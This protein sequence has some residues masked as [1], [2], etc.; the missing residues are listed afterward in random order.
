MDA[1]ISFGEWI[2][3]RRR[4]LDLTQDGLAALVNLS[5]SAIRK[6]ETDER[7]PSRE[8]AELL[9]EALEIPSDAHAAFLKTARGELAIHRLSAPS[10]AMP[11]LPTP[12]PPAGI[13]PV[14]P[15][16][17]AAPLPVVAAVARPP[18]LP[19]A[20]TPL[21]GRTNELLQI[22]RLLADPTCRLLTIVGPGGIGKTRLALEAATRL[23][24]PFVDGV[25]FVPLVSV[26]EPGLIAPTVA[27]AI[28]LQLHGARSPHEQVILHLQSR[29]ALL[30][31][32][33]LEHLLAPASASPAMNGSHGA[34]S[35]DWLAELLLQAPHLKLLTTSREPLGLPGEWLFDL[36]GLPTPPSDLQAQ[37]DGPERFSSIELFLQTARRT[38]ARFAPSAEDREAIARICRLVDG[39]PLGIEL[40]ASWVRT[41][42]CVEIADEIE[43]NLD[44]L[45][46][47]TRGLPERHRSLTAVVEQSWRLLSERERAA[48]RR[49]SILRGAFTRAA[50]EEVAGVNLALLSALVAKS[51]VRH[52]PQGRY[53]LHEV[54]RHYAATQL[55]AYPAE[56]ESAGEQHCRYF[57]GWLAQR[58]GWL[59]GDKQTAALEEFVAEADNI[60]AAWHW[61]VAQQQTSVIESATID[62]IDFYDSLSWFEEAERI[63]SHAEQQL[64]QATSPPGAL[65]CMFLG[66]GAF[67]CRIGRYDEAQAALMRSLILLRTVDDPRPLTRV[68]YWLTMVANHQGEY[69]QARQWAE[70][71]LALAEAH[72]FRSI[73]ARLLN[74]LGFVALYQGDYAQAQGWFEQALTAAR[75]LGNQNLIIL[76]LNN[77]STALRLQ[78]LYDRARLVLQESLTLTQS[79][80]ERRLMAFAQG[81]LGQLAFELGELDDAQRWFHQS[82][83]LLQEIH[84]IWGMTGV[85]NDLGHVALALEQPDEAYQHFFDLLNQAVEAGLPPR[86]L[87]AL[88]GMASLHQQ[89]GQ[90][91]AALA[92]VTHVMQ[93]PAVQHETKGRAERLYHALITQLPPD[94]AALTQAE[95]LA[96]PFSAL[97]EQYMQRRGRF[98]DAGA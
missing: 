94:E 42:T 52:T 2:R 30:L 66:W 26:G 25:Y 45:A 27:S 80:G 46:S 68:Y 1:P 83:R 21:I 50:A 62:L 10:V 11:P 40:A 98:T 70:L 36:H 93:H 63:F 4:A 17:I 28:G 3:Q 74:L 39:L 73:Y 71:G 72:D 19:R 82:L 69:H 32:D 9:A 53:D 77:L 87:D 23:Q 78:R 29:R 91:G 14:A 20:T 12:P 96:Q 90:V 7:R 59:R 16:A 61:A 56:A 33:N 88:T 5:V 31:L 24:E 38:D 67:S 76:L 41:L 97:V 58:G 47:P 57:M 79:T 49:L 48:L 85:L 95:A 54:V 65:G 6:I 22:E 86:I 18:S 34:D 81:S 51:L 15:P 75:Q 44:F 37:S 35:V 60:R 8:T 43:R 84:E 64:D 89:A 92:L 55:H 13:Q